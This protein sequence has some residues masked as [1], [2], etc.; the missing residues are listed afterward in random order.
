MNFLPYLIV[1][2]SLAKMWREKKRT[3]TGKNKQEKA[4]SKSHNAA[5]HCEYNYK[6]LTFYLEQLVR[7]LLRK[8]TVLI[9][10]K[11]K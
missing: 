3:H 2:I 11:E 5:S 10:Q 6:I 1:E 4:G 7:N 8:M 9:A